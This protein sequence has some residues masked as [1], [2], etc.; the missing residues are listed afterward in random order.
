MNGKPANV[1]PDLDTPDGY[2]ETKSGYIS[3]TPEVEDQILRYS[4]LMQENPGKKVV[5]ELFDGASKDVKQM[6]KK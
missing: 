4:K 2:R 5:Y 6:L 3:K 1:A